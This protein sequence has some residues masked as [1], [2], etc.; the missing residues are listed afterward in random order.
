[1]VRDR[2]HRVKSWLEDRQK[3]YFSERAEKVEPT[4]SVAKNTSS[5]TKMKL[6]KTDLRKF[7]ATL[8]IGLNSGTFSG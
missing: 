1:M 6:P 4:A 3:Q 5:T 8:W 7:S 2:I